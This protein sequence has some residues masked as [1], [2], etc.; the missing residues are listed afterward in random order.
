MTG[1]VGNSPKGRG[2]SQWM[3]S[4][5]PADAIHC[6]LGRGQKNVSKVCVGSN[7]PQSITQSKG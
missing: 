2:Q 5:F 3:G 7:V 4:H 6:G 1:T